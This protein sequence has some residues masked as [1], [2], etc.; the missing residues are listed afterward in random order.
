MLRSSYS[1]ARHQQ[2]MWITNNTGYDARE[3]PPQPH[4]RGQREGGWGD[5]PTVLNGADRTWFRQNLELASHGS[6]A[7]ATE[8]PQRTGNIDLAPS[9]SVQ[10]GGRIAGAVS[11]QSGAPL[12]LSCAP[13]LALRRLINVL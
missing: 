6:V 5:L 7:L 10:R 13:F 2:A 11:P 1:D 12:A 4:F 9:V 3:R 8:I